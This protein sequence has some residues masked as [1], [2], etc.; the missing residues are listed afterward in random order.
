[1]E[2]GRGIPGVEVEKVGGL[3][4]EVAALGLAGTTY[5]LIQAPDDGASPAVLDEA[6][7]SAESLVQ[8]S[9]ASVRAQAGAAASAT[10]AAI[11]AR[12]ALA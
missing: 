7:R 2:E 5:A 8:E 3:E 10:A 9:R 4:G 1:M 6:R 11:T 12:P